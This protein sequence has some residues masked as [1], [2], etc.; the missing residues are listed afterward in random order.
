MKAD[1]TF[2]RLNVKRTL[3]FTGGRR[4]SGETDFPADYQPTPRLR[5]ASADERRCGA[6]V[7]LAKI[8]VN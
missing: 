1:F 6:K 8:G 4:R 3:G 5:L 2:R 7:G